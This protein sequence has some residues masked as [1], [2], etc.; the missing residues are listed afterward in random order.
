ML[1]KILLVCGY[2]C[3]ISL[4]QKLKKK[5]KKNCTMW[6]IWAKETNRSYLDKYKLTWITIGT[7]EKEP[8]QNLELNMK[9][10][11]NLSTIWIQ[12]AIRIEQGLEGPIK[13]QCDNLIEPNYCFLNLFTSTHHIYIYTHTHAYLAHFGSPSWRMPYA[14]SSTC[15]HACH[16]LGDIIVLHKTVCQLVI[17]PVLHCLGTNWSGLLIH[18]WNTMKTSE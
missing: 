11:V 13:S 15:H 5:K 1:V 14:C 4:I 7:D 8:C 3:W 16:F 18:K 17:V 10:K 9:E 6:R 2:K 12:V